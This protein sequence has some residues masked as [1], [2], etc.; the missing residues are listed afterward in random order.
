MRNQNLG[1]LFYKY[2]E[3]WNLSFD[4]LEIRPVELRQVATPSD[5]RGFYLN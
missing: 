4:S 2:M 3:V 5:V 1:T